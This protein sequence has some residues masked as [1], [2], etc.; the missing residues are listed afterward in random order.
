MSPSYC[1][2]YLRLGHGSDGHSG[3]GGV[4]VIILL[5]LSNR[6][7]SGLTVYQALFNICVM[8]AAGTLDPA[9]HRSSLVTMLAS[10]AS[11]MHHEHLCTCSRCNERELR[12][13]AE[14]C[15]DKRDS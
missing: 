5:S 13:G 14:F 7:Q 2:L 8:T 3:G 11:V 1:V 6:R 4:F 10:A 15:K 9:W 12:R